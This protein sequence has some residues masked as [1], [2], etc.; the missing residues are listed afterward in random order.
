MS[1][2][3]QRRYRTG[4]AKSRHPVWRPETNTPYS[5]V[6]VYIYIHYDIHIYIYT[7]II[8]DGHYFQF[9]FDAPQVM[10]EHLQKI[11]YDFARALGNSNVV[12]NMVR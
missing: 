4:R 6:C 1:S 9:Q 8:I 12:A 2:Q 7:Y 10:T 11:G 3:P 5:P